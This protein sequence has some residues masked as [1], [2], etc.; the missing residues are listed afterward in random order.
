MLRQGSFLLIA[1]FAMLGSGLA[2]HWHNLEH[3]REDASLIASALGSERGSSH[4]PPNHN[5]SNCP[6]HAQLHL[7]ILPAGW[8]PALVCVGVFV[9]FLTMLTPPLVSQR[10][11]ER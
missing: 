9:A 6:T 1:V 5:D 11:C 10:R 8:V 2:E 3:A 7:Q 4:L